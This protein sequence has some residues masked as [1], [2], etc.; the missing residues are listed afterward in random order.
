MKMKWADLTNITSQKVVEKLIR[1]AAEMEHC[2]EIDPT[3]HLEQ[4]KEEL[5][6][7]YKK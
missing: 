5:T 7:D 3:H 6:C 1:K 4:F 2:Q